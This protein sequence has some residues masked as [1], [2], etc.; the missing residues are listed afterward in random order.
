M[1]FSL[2]K[3]AVYFIFIVP[4][5]IHYNEE[6]FF[7]VHYFFFSKPTKKNPEIQAN[8]GSGGIFFS[9]VEVVFEVVQNKCREKILGFKIC[10]GDLTVSNYQ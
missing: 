1:L 7:G 8:A 3:R 2:K 6:V 5:L 9:F 4:D 10:E